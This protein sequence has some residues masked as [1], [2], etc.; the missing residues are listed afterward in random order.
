MKLYA[1][2]DDI[3]AAIRSRRHLAFSYERDTFHT[4]EPY[5][6]GR[7]RRT[8]AIALV[9]KRPEGEWQTFRY[10]YIHSLEVCRET[11]EPDPNVCPIEQRKLADIELDARYLYPSRFGDR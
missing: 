5:L 7:V 4:V 6:L 10:C 1:S 2:L 11:F 3:R 9:A 8:G